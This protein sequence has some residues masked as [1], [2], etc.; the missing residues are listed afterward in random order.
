MKISIAICT[1]NGEKYLTDQLNSFA[2]QTLLPQE[3]VL[4]DDGSTDA[5]LKIVEKFQR[6]SGIT[7]NVCRNSERLG[8]VKN[9]EKAISLCTG[10]FIALSDQDDVWLPDKVETLVNEFD[11]PEN[12]N[13]NVIFTD[14]ALVD[15]DLKSLN[16]TVWKSF[17]FFKVIMSELNKK[18]YFKLLKERGNFVAGASTMMRKKIVN[19]LIPFVDGAKNWYHD[20]QIALIAAK[21]NELRYLDKP[22]VL[23]RQHEGQT[24]SVEEYHQPPILSDILKGI[25]EM[26]KNNLFYFDKVNTVTIFEKGERKRLVKEILFLEKRVSIL[27]KKIIKRIIPVTVQFFALNYLRFNGKRFIRTAISDF[28]NH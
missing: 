3:I 11:K 15:S 16:K 7:M 23:Y 21:N 5:T 17:E 24:V 26:K 20:G 18:G 6:E 9:F 2:Q 12:E 8:F 1:Y 28:L 10:D 25:I 27:G 14:M 19:K 22:L 4:C 13:V